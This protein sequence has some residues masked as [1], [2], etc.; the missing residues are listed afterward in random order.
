MEQNVI[1][2][3]RSKGTPLHEAEDKDLRYWVGRIE[4]DLAE[5]TA[6]FPDRDAPLAAAMRAEL[7]RRGEAPGSAPRAAPPPRSATPPNGNG[8]SRQ[9]ERSRNSEVVTGQ[10]ADSA[11]ATS[12]MLHA[13]EVAHLVAPAPACG[14]LPEGCE[15]TLSAV[16]VD[17]KNETY[18]VG[19][20]KGLSKVA[21]D[22]IAGA[23]GLSW[24]PRMSGRLDDGSDPHYCHYRAVG[25]MRLFDGSLR[26]LSGEVEI[27]AREGSSQIDEIET[28]ARKN[29]RDPEGQILELRKFLLRHAES[30]AKNRA[31]RSLGVRTSYEEA[32][33]AKPFV[34]ARLQFTG[35][36]E[37]PAAR[38]MFRSKI[39]DS[40][41][42][43]STSLYG[44][45][46]ALPAHAE[47]HAPPPLGSVPRDPAA[48]E[49]GYEPDYDRGDDPEAY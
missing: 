25:T 28:K 9:I 33:L 15:L 24:D 45:A 47:A 2:G 40:F 8:A 31:I 3:G 6:R 5:G 18:T 48:L 19:G 20:K 39:A 21:L 4:K 29:N 27:G 36:S 32:E 37:D 43:A 23:A 49:A 44:A 17:V 12:A 1:P 22:K 30:K 16:M 38:A 42:G 10:F 34:V 13:S 11:R 26:T 41:L 14:T 7:E 46:P 35:R